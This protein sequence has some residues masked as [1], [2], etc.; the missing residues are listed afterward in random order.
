[1]SKVLFLNRSF[2]PDTGATGQL[3]TELTE[4][5]AFDYEV[6]VIC[7]PA[8]TSPRQ[9]WPP[10]RRE[11]RGAVKIIRT[12]GAKLSKKNLR[13]RFASLGLYFLM[14]AVAAIRERADLIVAET[15]PPL[16]G[17]LGALMK[18]VKGCRFVYYCQDLY[19]DVAEATHA[20]RN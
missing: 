8:N 18:R 2:W 14:A 19:P 13:F 11:S 20:L 1:M 7:G 6:T 17:L 9:M 12:F 10:L 16:L 15:D 5:L 4:D 3:L